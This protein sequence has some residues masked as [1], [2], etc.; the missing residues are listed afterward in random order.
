MRCHLSH[1]ATFIVTELYVS[2]MTHYNT[3]IENPS[4]ATGGPALIDEDGTEAG[5]LS[6]QLQAV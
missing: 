6:Q 5:K 2:S 1:F 4:S 3:K